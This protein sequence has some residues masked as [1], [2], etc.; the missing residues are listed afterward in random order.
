MVEREIREIEIARAGGPSV[1]LDPTSVLDL[2]S[3]FA[4]GADWAPGK[5]V[6]DDGDARI[7]YALEGFL[8]TAGPDHRGHP[9]P[10]DEGEGRYPLHGSFAAHPALDVKISDDGS[11]CS[12]RVPVKLADGGEA[13][14]HREWRID[15][16]GVVH[17]NDRLENTGAKAFPPMMLYHM[18]IGTRL[19]GPETRFAGRMF[20]DGGLSWD[21]DESEVSVRCLPVEDVAEADGFATVKMGPVPGA[22][23]LTLTVGFDVSTLPQLQF[24]RNRQP[25]IH[26]F[27]IEP[28]SHRLEKRPVLKAAGEMDLLQPGEA[29]A[30]ALRFSFSAEG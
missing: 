14:L 23:N 7:F 5:D 27:G 1:W 3:V 19:F 20:E 26:V 28:C 4:G 12:A 30:Y 21:F 13:V 2:R 17:L 9:E 16:A 11:A 18:N 10:L 24:W 29:R 8:F 22:S 6:V 15:A 25:G